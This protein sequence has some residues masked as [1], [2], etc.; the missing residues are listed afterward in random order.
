M[1]HV[2]LDSL[3]VD[4]EALVRDRG[5]LS[6]MVLQHFV[7]ARMPSAPVGHVVDIAVDDNPKIALLLVLGH[8]LSRQERK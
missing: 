6:S 5:V 1:S 2:L 3:L 4:V 7:A 8:L